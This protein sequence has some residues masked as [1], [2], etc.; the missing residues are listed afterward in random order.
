MTIPRRR[1]RRYA[2]ILLP[3][4]T[5]GF[6]AGWKWRRKGDDCLGCTLWGES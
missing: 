5:A 6:I 3:A 1:V 2:A 4:L